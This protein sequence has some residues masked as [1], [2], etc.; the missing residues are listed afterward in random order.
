MNISNDWW[1]WGAAEKRKSLKS[2]PAF[3]TH[4]QGLWGKSF[5]DIQH[6][7]EQPQ[8]VVNQA[9]VAYVDQLFTTDLP[10]IKISVD[11]TLRLKRSLGKSY[12]DLVKALFNLPI[13]IP[14]AVVFPKNHDEVMQVLQFASQNAIMV[15]PFGGGSNVVGSF[16]IADKANALIVF[17]MSEMKSLLSIDTKNHTATFQ[18]GIMGPDIEAQLNA[19]GFTLGHF[20]QSFEFSSLG[21]WIAT[22]S[23]GQESSSYGRIEDIAISLKVATPSGTITTSGFEGDAEGINLKSLFFGSEGLFGVITEAKVRIHRL[24]ENKKWVVAVFPSFENGLETLKEL[25]QM[26]IFPSVVRFSDDH[27]SFFL[28]MLSHQEPSLLGDL[29]STIQKKVLEWK[30]IERPN[31]MLLRMDGNEEESLAKK[32]I[33]DTVARKN[34]GFLIGESLGKKWETSRFGLPYLRD[35]LMERGI[36]VDTMETVLPWDK[37]ADFRKHLLAQLKGCAAFGFDKGILLAHVSHVYNSSASIYFTVIT[38]Q[39]RAQ[40]VEQWKTI[41]ALVT[42]TIVKAGGAVSHHHSVGRDHQPWY[43][44]RT[45]ALTKK[46]LLSIKKTLDPQHIMNPGNLFDE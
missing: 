12:F 35:D 39:D 18:G 29:K 20:P 36:F 6:A 4:L 7:P 21:G 37:L 27:E 2:Y 46:L 25:V 13:P 10:G 33:A 9:R 22:R 44:A 45:D 42:D 40:P 31:L 1:K 5:D 30:N 38:A 8:L 19:K 23:A 28:S 3:Q 41:K 24:P 43:L 15:L 26:D 14:E 17:D 16:N 34:Q 32:N 11:P